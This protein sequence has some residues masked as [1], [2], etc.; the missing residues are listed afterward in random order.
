LA[1]EKPQGPP[2]A[3][4]MQ[5]IGLLNLRINDMMSQLNAVLKS[6]IDENTALQMENAELKGTPK[7]NTEVKQEQ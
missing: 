6:M 3:P 1:I 7:T 2:S 4:L 5:Q